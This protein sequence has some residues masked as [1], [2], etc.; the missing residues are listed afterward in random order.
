[1]CTQTININAF[2]FSGTFKRIFNAIRN[3]VSD[4]LQSWQKFIYHFADWGKNWGKK[5]KKLIIVTC[6][7]GRSQPLLC[8][9]WLIIYR[10][11]VVIKPY[12]GSKILFPLGY[13]KKETGET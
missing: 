12:K 1:M 9:C 6:A 11:E 7:V 3:Q 4:P 10:E 8:P 5:K 2:Y 13:Q